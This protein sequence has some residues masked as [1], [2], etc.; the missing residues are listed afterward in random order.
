MLILALVILVNADVVGRSLF[1]SPISGVPEIVAMSI[2][3]IVFLQMA[4]AFRMG[5]FT[6]S[7]AV[8]DGIAKR[9]PR[10]RQII[11]ATYIIAALYLIWVLLWATYPLFLKAWSRD[12][13]IG[14]IGDFTAPVW[15]IKFIIIVG[16]AALILQLLASL[17]RAAMA[18]VRPSA[19]AGADDPGGGS[20]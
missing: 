6:R 11:E 19:E 18:I 3:A 7:T 16:C 13:F 15:P 17:V 1:L 9:A 5:R 12:T 20:L 8:L 14:T 10:L 4:H 2:V